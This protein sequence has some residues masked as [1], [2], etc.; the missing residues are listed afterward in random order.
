MMEATQNPNEPIAEF[1]LRLRVLATQGN[2]YSRCGEG[3][4]RIWFLQHMLLLTMMKGLYDKK[5]RN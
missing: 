2:L 4:C 1:V 5:I 3:Y